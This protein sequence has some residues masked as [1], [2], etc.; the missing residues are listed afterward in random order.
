MTEWQILPIL[1]CWERYLKDNKHNSL[2]LTLKIYS[3]IGPW[4][5]SAPRS[6]Q[7]SSSNFSLIGTDNVRGQISEHVFAPN[8]FYCLFTTDSDWLPYPTLKSKSRNNVYNFPQT[9]SNAGRHERSY[10]FPKARDAYREVSGCFP[11]YKRYYNLY[12]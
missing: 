1:E 5:L 11:R 6:S 4:T 8:G 3:H 10:P 12:L 7:L 2:H 9:G